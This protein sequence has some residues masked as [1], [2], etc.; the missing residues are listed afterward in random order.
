M[1]I[2]TKY[3]GDPESESTL[4][5]L[6]RFQHAHQLLETHIPIHGHVEVEFEGN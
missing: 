4:R 3:I 1:M 5:I 6:R 2:S